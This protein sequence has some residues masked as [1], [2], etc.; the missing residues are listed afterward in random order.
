LECR[1]GRTSALSSMLS[2]CIFS[3]FA[4]LIFNCLLSKERGHKFVEKRNRKRE[5]VFESNG[6]VER[7][8]RS[9]FSSKRRSDDKSFS[10][11]R[12]SFFFVIFL[13][14]N[15][16]QF[17]FFFIKRSARG[18]NSSRINTTEKAFTSESCYFESHNELKSSSSARIFFLFAFIQINLFA[19]LI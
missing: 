5:N 13:L 19:F 18:I 14:T 9:T 8:M 17:C 12:L 7:R 10:K 3:C 6:L 15:P 4:H 16:K 1:S 2:N 11:V